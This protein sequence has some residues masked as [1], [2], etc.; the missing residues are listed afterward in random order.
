MI[1]K[2]RKERKK[3]ISMKC[4]KNVLCL[5]H[6]GVNN[7]SILICTK[8]EKTKQFANRNQCLVLTN[9]FS[10]KLYTCSILKNL[11]FNRTEI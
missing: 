5:F 7:F 3:Y 6:F 10:T 8:F 9:W 2:E 1:Y 11:N 4:I